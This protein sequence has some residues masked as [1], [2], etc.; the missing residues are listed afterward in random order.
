MKLKVSILGMILFT[1]IS[2]SNK[3]SENDFIKNENDFIRIQNI[4]SDN[5]PLLRKLDSNNF[6][7]NVTLYPNEFKTKCT[8]FKKEDLDF[9]SQVFDNK[10][11]K[12]I[13]IYDKNC[14]SFIL[15]TNSGYINGSVDYIIYSVDI[16]NFINE[17]STYSKEIKEEKMLKKN[18]YYLK[19]RIS[20][21][22]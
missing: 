2:C 9:I 11:I 17:K 10:I 5:Y 7:N 3:K 4:L 14:I 8:F 1:A 20:L 19:R 18:W 16:K 21:S 12:Y 13:S 6:H 22:N 15:E